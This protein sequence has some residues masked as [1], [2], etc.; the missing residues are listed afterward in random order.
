MEH[1]ATSREWEKVVE[2]LYSY[3]IL[4]P[5][6]L[7]MGY[8]SDRVLVQTTSVRVM[9]EV[10]AAHKLEK[11]EKKIKDLNGRSKTLVIH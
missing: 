10:L 6:V 5:L 1:P 2:L 4:A 3:K 11:W 9:V 7:D 8:W